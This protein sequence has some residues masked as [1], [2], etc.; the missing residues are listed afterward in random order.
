MK[1]ALFLGAGASAFVSLPTTKKLL[2]LV[3]ERVQKRASEQSR[4]KNCQRYIMSVIKDDTY[5][6]IEQLYDGMEQII[7]IA[8]NDN[9]RPVIGRIADQ[10]GISY[11]QIIE[12][13]EYLR[14]AV[15]DTLLESLRIDQAMHGSIKQVYD[16]VRTIMRS[17]GMG[18]TRLVPSSGTE[19]FRVFTTNYDLVMEEYGRM[20]GF[21]IVN[22]F[23]P[24]NYLGRA[25]GNTWDHSAERLMY[26][27]KLHGS[28]NWWRNADDDI[29]ETGGIQDRNADD[30]IMVAPTEGGK[31]YDEKPF[32][33]LMER[34]KEEMGEVDVLLAIGFSYRDREIVSI[35][36]DRLDGGMHLISLSPTAAGDIR[37]VKDAEPE[38]VVAGG[39]HLKTVGPRIILCETEF[40]PNPL[41]A[42]RASLEAAYGIIRSNRKNST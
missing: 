39:V 14:R 9:C 4:D 15:R 41:D 11:D 29:L 30:D 37:R 23:K 26:L 21:E 40:G 31:Q 5:N 34:F 35:I 22:G 1:S 6:D 20:A 27:T 8:G 32:R 2:G 16:K 13:L 17:D 18:K 12:E 42:V 10:T 19:A 3:R 28:V 33:T 36:R 25:W 24:A 38:D 7:N